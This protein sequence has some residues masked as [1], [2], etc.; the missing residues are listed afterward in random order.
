[1]SHEFCYNGLLGFSEYGW[2]FSFIVFEIFILA[3]GYLYDEEI[4]FFII[5]ALAQVL[6]WY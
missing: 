6:H 4:T 3:V 1:M 2:N 5:T